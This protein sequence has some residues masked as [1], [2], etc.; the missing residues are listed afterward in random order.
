M[1][2]EA[3]TSGQGEDTAL[4]DSLRRLGLPDT[5]SMNRLLHTADAK[6]TSTQDTDGVLQT[7]IANTLRGVL[8]FLV[9]HLVGRQEAHGARQ[10]IEKYVAVFAF[11]T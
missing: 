2:S 4:F 3:A 6:N 5:I 11:L 10:A 8:S 7:E 9:S 1:S